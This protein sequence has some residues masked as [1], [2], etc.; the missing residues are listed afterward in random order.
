[1]AVE[2]ERRQLVAAVA[3][4]GPGPRGCHAVARDACDFLWD[5][6]TGSRWQLLTGNGQ[7]F[8]QSCNIHNAI[9][10]LPCACHFICMCALLLL[11]SFCLLHCK[12]YYFYASS[13]SRVVWQVAS[14]LVAS[15]AEYVVLPLLSLPLSLTLSSFSCHLNDSLK[16]ISFL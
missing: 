15:T 3:A 1:M 9:L 4:T 7:R 2:E 13:S 12:N 11:L 16:V 6:E 14:L 8:L 10:L 5:C